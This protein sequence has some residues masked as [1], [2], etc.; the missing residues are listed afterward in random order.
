MDEIRANCGTSCS[1]ACV[2]TSV[3][4]VPLPPDSV[5]CPG[6]DSG[7]YCDCSGDCFFPENGFCYCEEAAACCANVLGP[8][9]PPPPPLGECMHQCSTKWSADWS[10]K[11]K[12]DQ[13][14]GCAECVAP[15]LDPCDAEAWSRGE[16]ATEMLC[17]E[18]L[19]TGHTCYSTLSEVCPSSVF[20]DVSEDSP[21]CPRAA[22][23]TTPHIHGQ[24]SCDR[25]VKLTRA[26]AGRPPARPPALRSQTHP[27][28]RCART[29]SRLS[30]S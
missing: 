24:A 3:P 21:L 6:M 19:A 28:A 20:L 23:R 30:R 13:C 10:T 17:M 22:A 26:R 8:V 4:S 11:C 29:R 14:V 5:L 7:A 12:W 1:S 27:G 15:D 9:P 16:D 18:I 25:C 2:D